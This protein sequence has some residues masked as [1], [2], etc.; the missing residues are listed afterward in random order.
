MC[1]L[2]PPAPT[3]TA[4]LAR[5]RR[6]G[7]RCLWRAKRSTKA[8]C[9]RAPCRALCDRPM[10]YK[11]HC[12][13]ERL[14]SVGTRPWRDVPAEAS[15]ANQRRVSRAAQARRRPCL[16]EGGA[17]LRLAAR[18][19]SAALV[20]VG[21]WRAKRIPSTRGLSPSERARGATCQL[22]PPAPTSA[23]CLARRR[24]AGFRCLEKGGAA[25]RLAACARRTAL[26]VV[27]LRHIKGHCRGERPVSF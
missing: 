8:C 2:R 6:A 21:P 3:N 7:A 12:L 25:L 16:W 10:A 11:R 5:R 1:Q 20:V 27:G 17:A 15:N 19:R 26:V 24:R 13:G 18:A 14:L 23:A 22:R 9:L 4:F